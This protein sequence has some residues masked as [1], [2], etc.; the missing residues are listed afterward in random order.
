MRADELCQANL[1]NKLTCFTFP[2]NVAVLTLLLNEF[3]LVDDHGS[4]WVQFQLA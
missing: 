2:H 1:F 3:E 4:L